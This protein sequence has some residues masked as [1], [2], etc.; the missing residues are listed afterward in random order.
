MS[1]AL[2]VKPKVAS[3]FVPAHIKFV[4]GLLP[5]EQG[6][7]PHEADGRLTL[8]AEMD[9][10]CTQSPVRP[11]CVQI[12]AFRRTSEAKTAEM[13]HGASSS[14]AS[15]SLK[16]LLTSK[17]HRR[18]RS[19]PFGGSKN[20]QTRN[21]V[22]RALPPRGRRIRSFARSRMRLPQREHFGWS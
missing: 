5:D 2:S 12:S 16:P 17:T 6:N 4:G 13:I 22:Y 19:D 9:R 14:Y 11:S 21:R 15:E 10:I 8:V 18:D 20:D 7:F 1:A 3:G